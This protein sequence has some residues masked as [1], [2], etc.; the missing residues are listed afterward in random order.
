MY[1]RFFCICI[2]GCRMLPVFQNK[3]LIAGENSRQWPK[4]TCCRRKLQAMAEAYLLPEKTPGYGRSVLV[5]GENTRQWP[6]RTCC[7]R[8]LQAMAES[9]LLPEKTPG[10]SESG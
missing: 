5:A 4:R 8:K 1:R 3:L 6:K 7:R 9:Y 10:N 2:E